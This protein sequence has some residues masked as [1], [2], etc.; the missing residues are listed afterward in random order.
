M[1]Y[2]KTYTRREMLK[3]SGNVLG[4]SMLAAI[5]PGLAREAAAA[6]EELVV[7]F[8]YTGPKDD[9]GWN[10]S[11]AVAAQ[12]IA[13]MDN[14]RV[15]EQENVPET[16][17]VSNVMQSMIELDGASVVFPTSFGF[18][19]FILDLAPRYENVLFVHAGARWEDGDPEN[20]IGYRGYMEEGH[21]C[22]GI[23]A[24]RLTENNRIGFVGPHPTYFTFN[25]CNGFTMGA[26][27][28]NS[29]VTC[30]VILTGSWN[31]PTREAEAVNSM[32]DQGVDVIVAN[33]DSPQVAIETAEKRGIYSVGYHT[34]QSDLAPEGFITG[35]EWNWGRGADFVKAWRNDG[36]YP[37][38]L[39]G[40]FA[41]DMIVLSPFGQ[42][43][44]DEIQE[45]VLAARE[46]FRDGSLYFYKGPLKDADGN[47]KL[48][49]GE[50]VE[51]DDHEFKVSVDWFVE[52]TRGDTDAG[53]G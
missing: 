19:D 45:E 34:D 53:K 35:T 52:G 15:L 44:T 29:D 51:N 5:V 50:T 20:T 22:A 1:G 2:R 28:V 41:E 36:D 42:A 17:E 38:L 47:V 14:V 10:Q 4:F 12:Q 33:V 30:R 48:E 3:T 18:W 25:N 39:R 46:G 27:S 26:R 40:G 8:I 11:H 21:Y 31:D 9:F 32:I 49:E 24:G 37:N 43:V 23:A 6:G 13:E 16:E 7:G